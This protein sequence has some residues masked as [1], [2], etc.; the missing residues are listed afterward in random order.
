MF[1]LL[2]LVDKMPHIAEKSEKPSCQPKLG[3]LNVWIVLTSL[4]NLSHL[5]ID[6]QDKLDVELDT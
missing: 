6:S 4:S 1:F 3:Q 5:G 2:H